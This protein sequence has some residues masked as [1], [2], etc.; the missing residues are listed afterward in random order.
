MD[1]LF[2]LDIIESGAEWVIDC[3]TPLGRSILQIPAPFTPAQLE[4]GLQ[5]IER[6]MLR[7]SAPVIMRSASAHEQQVRDFGRVLSTA[8]IKD[9][10]DL[11]FRR[12]YDKARSGQHTMRVLINPVGAGIA[13][14]PWEFTLDPISRDDYLALRVPMA[15]SPHL[16]HGVAPLRVDPP[17][18]VLGVVARPADLP[19]LDV[20]AER[21][22]ISAVFDQLSTDLV[23]VTWLGGDRWNDLAV[24]LR[25]QPWHVLHFVGHG[26]FDEAEQTGYLELSDD[27][28]KSMRLPAADLARLVAANQNL[29]LVVL[30]ACDS[31]VAGRDGGVFSSTAAKL[32][33][34]GVPAVVAMQYE[35]TDPAALA[36]ACSFYE[37][38]ARG[39]QVD[40]AVTHAREQV[41]MTLHSLEWAT[42]VLFL[43]S[44]E[45]SVFVR[46]GDVDDALPMGW[47]GRIKD[48]VTVTQQN[49]LPPA[50]AKKPEPGARLPGPLLHVA[51]G[52]DDL[53]AAA[54]ADGMLR[55][56]TAQGQE[57]ATCSLPWQD[58]PVRVAWSPWRRHLAT[59][60]ESSTVVVWDLQTEVPVRLVPSP[61][62]WARTALAFSPDGQWLAMTGSDLTVRVHDAAGAEVLVIPVQPV[63]QGGGPWPLRPTHLPHLRFSP[64]SQQLLVAA[65]DGVVRLFDKRGVLQRDWRHPQAVTA[66]AASTELIVVGCADGRT[67]TWTWEGEPHL[68]LPPQ[69]RVRFVRVSPDGRRVALVGDDRKL[70]VW[71]SAGRLLAERQLP[72][73]AVGLGFAAASDQVLVALENGT[74]HAFGARE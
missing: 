8:V 13:R 37:A 28:G 60:H 45:A 61:T 71:S 29:R 50:T 66:L 62:G 16:L 70:M 33:R 9:D 57:R 18:R 11:L 20:D 64:D 68:R 51:Y 5:G 12:C 36:F 25:S 40:V 42:P 55:V 43:A 53:I 41:K 32:M 34:E 47:A 35:I 38:I 21:R 3:N 6:S 30:N 10:V 65:D 15:R 52:P 48:A 39:Q 44:E 19:Q 54:S 22:R 56:V 69:G 63:M 24:A 67:R 7:S 49:P 23:K 46:P 74:L 2:R 14:I 31:A 17:L 72:A 73:Q 27:A 4:A 58:R 59:L 1:I 26:G